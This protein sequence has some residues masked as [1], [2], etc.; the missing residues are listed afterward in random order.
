MQHQEFARHLSVNPAEIVYDPASSRQTLFQE[1]RL[2]K[3]EMIDDI[4]ELKNYGMVEDEGR[5]GLGRQIAEAIDTDKRVRVWQMPGHLVG[6]DDNGRLILTGNPKSNYDL[7]ERIA[8]VLGRE[9]VWATIGKG[10]LP[11]TRLGH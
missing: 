1:S 8:R 5:R 11:R 6:W 4:A 9:I 3:T 7:A 10:E 2:S